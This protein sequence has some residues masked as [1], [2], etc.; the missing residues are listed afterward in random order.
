MKDIALVISCG[1]SRGL[2]AIGAIEE[3]EAS[4]FN[5]TSIAGSSIGSAIGGIYASGCLPEYKKWI[6]S[7]DRIDVYKLMDFTISRQGFLKGVKVFREMSLFFKDSNI[8]D[9]PISYAAV[10]VDLLTHKQVIFK[11]GSL[12]RAIRSSCSIPSIFKPNIIEGKVLVDGGVSNPLPFSVVEKKSG[13]LLVG[14]DLNAPDF[15]TKKKTSYFDYSE[16]MRTI[17]SYLHFWHDAS[18][19]K[20]PPEIGG[21]IDIATKSFQIMQE[22]LTNRSIQQ[23]SPDLLIKIPRTAS[24]TFEFFKAKELIKLGRK[25]TKEAIVNSLNITI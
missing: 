9:L 22:E 23:Y 1:G 7:L 2:A 14:I 11:E 16:F 10:S 5:I 8:E 3:L 18:E 24:S 17:N 20:L 12:Y 19:N 15:R 6:C 25:V 21:P 13:D 4:G